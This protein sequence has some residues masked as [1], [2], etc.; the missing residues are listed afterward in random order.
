MILCA[1]VGEGADFY[2]LS[3]G[4]LVN[5]YR[6]AYRREVPGT[7]TGR[8]EIKPTRSRSHPADPKCPGC[9]E[10]RCACGA[11]RLPGLPCPCHCEEAKP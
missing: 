4:T 2:Y 8:T 5:G 6:H 11:M 3:Y 1:D 10:Y 9:S 7:R